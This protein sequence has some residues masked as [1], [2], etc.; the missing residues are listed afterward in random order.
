M[1]QLI[2]ADVME[3]TIKPPRSH[4]EME[5]PTSVAARGAYCLC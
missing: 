1:R 3:A 2:V 4:G 5:K